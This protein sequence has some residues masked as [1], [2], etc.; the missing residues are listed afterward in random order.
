MP[1]EELGAAAYRKYDIECW[2]PFR[3]GYGE[4]SSAS[5]CTDFQSRRLNIRYQVEAGKNQFVHTLNA[6]ACAVPRLLLA[7][8]ETYQQRDGSVL[9]PDP[10]VPFVGLN[11]ITRRN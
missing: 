4:I 5:N 6:T 1:T 3:R 11:R 2:M 8:M 10:L 7:L 9:V